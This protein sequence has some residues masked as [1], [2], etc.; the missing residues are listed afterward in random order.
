MSFG[1]G[2]IVRIAIVLLLLLCPF[3]H[4]R[5]L[6]NP[7]QLID[8][9]S[10]HS[11]KTLANDLP[12]VDTA[13]HDVGR[14][15]LFV[16]NVGSFLWVGAIVGRDT[17][18]S[19]AYDGWVGGFEFWPA[20]KKT[21]EEE[22]EL[23]MRRSIN[24]TL[25]P[26][27]ELAKSEQDII[28]Y[29]TDTVLR[30]AFIPPIETPHRPLGIRIKRS[31]Y[32]WSY[33]YAEDFI[34]FDYK[35]TNISF[36]TLKSVYIGLFGDDGFDS[37][38]FRGL[39]R[40]A[41]TPVP[42]N[43]TCD[44]TSE[45]NIAW[46]AH[47]SG[48]P[49][50]NPLTGGID[51]VTNRVITGLRILNP[52]PN[53]ILFSYNWWL[54]TSNILTDFGPRKR[55]SIQKPFRNMNGRLGT[56]FG[57]ENRY[58]VISNHEIDYD[59]YL[60]ALDH[61]AQGW[62][63]P[64]LDAAE[65]SDGRGDSHYLQSV[66]P[67][68]IGPGETVSF[69][70]AYIVGDSFHQDLNNYAE[71]FNPYYPQPFIDKLDFSDLVENATWADWIY[72]NPGY[73]TN[74]DGYRGDFIVCFTPETTFD[75]SV[76]IDTSVTPVDTSLVIDTLLAP[77]KPDTIYI[78]GD[79]V[80]DFRGAAAPEEPETRITTSKGRLLFEWNGLRSETTPDI[81]SNELDFEGYRVFVGRALR[82]ADLLIYSSYDI[83]DFTQYYF[84]PRPGTIDK[85][86]WVILRKPFTLRE[87]QLAYAGGNPDYDPLFNEI[88]N[89][90]FWSDDSTFYFVAQDFNQSDLSDTTAIHKIYPN[91]PYPHTLDLGRAFTRDTLYVDPVSG[92]ETFYE[93]GE[94]TPDGKYFKYFEYR[95]IADNLLPSVEYF[96]G[97][98]AFDYGSPRSNVP[99]LETN[100][101]R[102]ARSAFP[103][104]P[105]DPDT[106]QRLNVIVY[107][108]PY[109]ND[110]AYREDGFEAVGR[111]HLPGFLTREIHFVNLPPRCKISIFSL[112][113]DLID[114]LEHDKPP[115]DPS[116]MHESWDL[117]SRNTQLVTSGIFYWIVETPGGDSQIGKLVIIM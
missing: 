10:F 68:T 28:V 26:D 5:Q 58:H 82:R 112:D 21:Q 35:I 44:F 9:A 80:P 24:D 89:P 106:A 56:P 40:Y 77:E 116:A 39:K 97:V 66:G 47:E 84:Q 86:D 1:L 42:R 4:A 73:D 16:G 46:H 32:A 79:G 55:G 64:P 76:V 70:F 103:L 60:T 72:D 2:K 43:I 31:S 74:R 49:I 92:A 14:L 69:S 54:T 98:T 111:E 67:Y 94:L 96:I 105:F 34:L 36:K 33:E 37:L 65:I 53:Q 113:G 12:F 20:T 52:S 99:P 25:A 30:D 8:S 62:L 63:P 57:D 83:E 110:G 23:L 75:T 87:T 3:S 71:N 102:V 104:E 114:F 22:G 61:S 19:T 107:P 45:L 115:G 91:A 81:F 38:G 109:R 41:K 90:L 15:N 95:Y 11:Y 100:P 108:N 88:D 6:F 101:L 17:L 93:D 13:S 48:A 117:L 18:V 27:H 59:Q 50:T 85:G 51:S 78:S 7:Q 29:F